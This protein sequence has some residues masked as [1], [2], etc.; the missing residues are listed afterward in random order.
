ML[1]EKILVCVKN[2]SIHLIFTISVTIKELTYVS[3]LQSLNLSLRRTSHL[4][5]KMVW[6]FS[7]FFLY[8]KITVM[9][10]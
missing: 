10:V 4:Q 1:K 7:W 9:D 6:L 5:L 3:H 2:L 8:F